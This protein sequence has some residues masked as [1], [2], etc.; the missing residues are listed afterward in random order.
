[1]SLMAL[2]VRRRRVRCEVLMVARRM[3]FIVAILMGITALTAGLAAPPRQRAP[4]TAPPPQT[5]QP[6]QAAAD[7]AVVPGALGDGRRVRTTAAQKGAHLIL[8]AAVDG[9]DSVEVV[10]LDRIAAVAPGTP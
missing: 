6:A 10:G 7:A 5:A 8:T 1:M 2:D 4:A 9:L 3:L